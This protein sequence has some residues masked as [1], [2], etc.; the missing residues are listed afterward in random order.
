MHR[1]EG[2]TLATGSKPLASRTVKDDD[3]PFPV[4]F[5]QALDDDE[6]FCLEIEE[7]QC[8]LIG[9]LLQSLRAAVTLGDASPIGK[10][11]SKAI[12]ELQVYRQGLA[13]TEQ[14]ASRSSQLRQTAEAMQMLL[15]ADDERDL[16]AIVRREQEVSELTDLLEA[17]ENV[18]STDVNEGDVTQAK[19]GAGNT[20]CGGGMCGNQ[21]AVETSLRSESSR[22][23]TETGGVLDLSALVAQCTTSEELSALCNRLVEREIASVLAANPHLQFIPEQRKRVIRAQIEATLATVAEENT[24]VAKGPSSCGTNRGCQSCPSKGSCAGQD[25]TGSSSNPGMHIGS[26]GTVKLSS[27]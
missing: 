1:E 7:Q 24:M 19:S 15:L 27:D 16:M 8:V 22:E 13:D 12:G 26:D 6:P 18:N 9:E 21:S 20:C 23:N 2:Q 10:T 14:L 17:F 5:E 4:A 3:E 11:L 25:A